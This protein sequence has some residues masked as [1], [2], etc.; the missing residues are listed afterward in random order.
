ME[1]RGDTSLIF[2]GNPRNNPHVSRCKPPCI[3][4]FWVLSPSLSLLTAIRAKPPT[5]LFHFSNT[6]SSKLSKENSSLFPLKNREFV[7]FKR[8][9]FKLL[10]NLVSYYKALQLLIQ[11]FTRNL[12][13]NHS[14][15]M[16]MLLELHRFRKPPQE[17][18]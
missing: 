8:L 11:A 13:L 2:S 10:I 7:C 15:F 1:L 5:T 3:N 14:H 17:A 16:S 6:L 9:I 12:S 18:S 4:H